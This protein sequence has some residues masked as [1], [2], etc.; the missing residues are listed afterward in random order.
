MTAQGLGGQQ[1]TKHAKSKQNSNNT[2]ATNKQ[3]A[4]KKAKSF[5]VAAPTLGRTIKVSMA[6]NIALPVFFVNSGSSTT[7]VSGTF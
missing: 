7:K 1:A 4:S 2:Q 5:K 6:F 3:Q